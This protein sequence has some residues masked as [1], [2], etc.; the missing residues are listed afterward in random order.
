MIFPFHAAVFSFTVRFLEQEIFHMCLP[1]SIVLCAYSKDSENIQLLG[2]MAYMEEK[3]IET[4]GV[5]PSGGSVAGF[6][7]TQT[8]SW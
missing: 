6:S 2:T 5:T 4:A 8:A 1:P 3:F 7:V